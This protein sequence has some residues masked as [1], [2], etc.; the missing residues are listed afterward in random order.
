MAIGRSESCQVED[1]VWVGM[2][3]KVYIVK[4]LAAR[5]ALGCK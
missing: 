4:R 2:M 1:G 5:K 3:G